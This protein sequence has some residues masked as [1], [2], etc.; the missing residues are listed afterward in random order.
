VPEKVRAAV[1]V[2]PGR[3]EV[4]KFPYPEVPK[5][6]ALVKM[7]MSGI[8][9]TDKDMYKGEIIHPGGVTTPFPIIPGH[10]NVGV[11]AE[12]G[13]EAAV[14]ME[15]EGHKL[16]KGDRVVAACDVLCGECYWCRHGFSY[17]WCENWIGYGTTI[18]C[19]DPPHLF[20]G[21]SEYM[22]IL[23]KAFLFKVPEDM[24]LETAVLTEPMAVAYGALSKA[25]SPCS[26]A[27]DMGGFGAGDTVV[28]QGPG[29]LGLCHA[30]MAR[31]VGVERIVAVGS[32]SDR[33]QYRLKLAEDLGIIDYGVNIENPGKRVK[34]VLRL[35][36][37]R[38]ADLVIEC[39]GAPQALLEG[40]EM[41]RR[42]GTYLELGNFIDKG[43]T[44]P[45]NPAL[46][47]CAKNARIIG[48]TGMPYH[49]YGKALRVMYKY[50][51]RFPFADLVTHKFGL[52]D[53]EE[54]MR[55]A[56]RG[57]SLKVVITP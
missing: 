48:V 42:G 43:V 52:E 55:V 36:G 21:W 11:I 54:A 4:K 25:S 50:G 27:L 8:C 15:V 6:A 56:M 23:P 47:I 37:S 53:V 7:E 13:E 32:G 30:L 19:K 20:G 33:D 28:V 18:S 22:Y 46:H 57:K 51:D 12:I 35:I 44:V 10:E 17:P 16:R 38:G 5:D 24:P 2:E 9:G 1:M 40:L 31:I 26:L 3:I 14:R 34:E 45:L 41:L 49:A 39:A 29:P